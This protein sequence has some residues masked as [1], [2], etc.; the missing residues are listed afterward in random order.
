MPWGQVNAQA[1]L[2][3]ESTAVSFQASL[4]WTS[5]IPGTK[6]ILPTA[7]RERSSS[8]MLIMKATDWGRGLGN[9]GGVSDTCLFFSTS[10]AQVVMVVPLVPLAGSKAEFP[11]V[12][13]I[14]IYSKRCWSKKKITKM[15][16]SVQ[17][18]FLGYDR[19]C[20]YNNIKKRAHKQKKL[21]EKFAFGGNG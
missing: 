5:V 7:C 9:K 2:N 12:G 17:M 10:L 20:I 15:F 14:R 11:T 16:A 13:Q 19:F 18:V 3:G 21:K 4:S 6:L 8:S 1:G